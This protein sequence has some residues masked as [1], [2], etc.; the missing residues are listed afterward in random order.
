MILRECSVC[1][2]ILGCS[3]TLMLDPSIF[4]AVQKPIEI[5]ENM[6][7]PTHDRQIQH[8]VIQFV[9]TAFTIYDQ[10]SLTACLDTILLRTTQLTGYLGSLLSSAKVAI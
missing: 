5:L 9:F 10:I 1:D 2:F 3:I 4:S 6:F 8:N 7:L